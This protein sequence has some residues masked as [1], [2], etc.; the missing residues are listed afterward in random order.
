MAASF[1]RKTTKRFFTITTGMVAG[2]YL[3]ACLVPFLDLSTWWVTGFLAIGFPYLATVLFFCFLFWLIVKPK[4]AIPFFIVFVLG[5]KQLNV[6]LAVNTAAV[7]KTA[8]APNHL[9]IANWNIRS[10]EGLVTRDKKRF[11]RNDVTDCITGTKA[12]VV[13]LQ[14]FNHSYT[15][16]Q[17]SNNLA[18]FT[19]TYP[20]YYFARDFK[21]GNGVY[22]SGSIIFSKYPIIDSGKIV[23]P[24]RYSESI[25]YAD[26]VQGKDT[27]RIFTT[28]LQSFRFNRADYE[29]MEQIR[30][31]KEE[32]IDASVGLVQKMKAAF[33]KR[34]QQANIVRETIDESPYPSVIC[35]DFNDVPNSYTYAHIKGKNRNDVFLAKGLGIGRT[36][37]ALAPT[38][39]I[40][41]ILPDKRFSIHQMDMVDEDL[42]DHIMLVADISL[43]K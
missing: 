35:G 39:R 3:L 12:D 40:D 26:I 19:Q 10:F 36:Y 28:H 15:K 42:S 32:A 37:I 6:L 43:K 18:L 7:Y 31:S 24:G 41:Y 9:R 34:G 14:E 29:G 13:C 33:I 23:F 11:I 17:S 16:G 2:L 25:I 27:I 5:F 21:K 20:Y 38:L 4:Y 30:Q 22:V 1:L 8:I